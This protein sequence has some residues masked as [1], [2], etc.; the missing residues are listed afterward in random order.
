MFMSTMKSMLTFQKEVHISNLFRLAC[1]L[2]AME[3]CYKNL[4]NIFYDNS[5][6]LLVAV[7]FSNSVCTVSSKQE[8]NIHMPDTQLPSDVDI[9]STEKPFLQEGPKPLPHH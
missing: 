3:Q 8:Q 7:W 4:R 2:Y 6:L 1:Y 9:S 5:T